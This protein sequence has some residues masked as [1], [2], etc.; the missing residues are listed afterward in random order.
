MIK[1]LTIKID[2]RAKN[3]FYFLFLT[4]TGASVKEK[5]FSVFKEV[6]SFASI[7]RYDDIFTSPHRNRN[8]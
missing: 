7:I 5:T 1:K 8:E 2:W 4:G 6:A 3:L